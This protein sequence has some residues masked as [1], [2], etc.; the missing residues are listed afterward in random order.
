MKEVPKLVRE[1][2][3]MVVYDATQNQLQRRVSEFIRRAA[4]SYSL[5]IPWWQSHYQAQA[6]E[7]FDEDDII[8]GEVVAKELS[9]TELLEEKDYTDKERKRMRRRC[10]RAISRRE[11]TARLEGN[12]YLL[13]REAFEE[14]VNQQVNK[15]ENNRPAPKHNALAGRA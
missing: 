10:Y 2:A 13:M 6:E 14:F 4:G 1:D 8:E 7:P 5:A 3:S 9:L 11:L 12:R 15:Q